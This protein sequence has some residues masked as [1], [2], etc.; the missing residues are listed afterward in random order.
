[1]TDEHC[2]FAHR[3]Q[4]ENARVTA[5]RRLH[6]AGGFFLNACDAHATK[7]GELFTR[8]TEIC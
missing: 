5:T 4:P 6:G 8:T 7:Y 3:E 2:H 1:M